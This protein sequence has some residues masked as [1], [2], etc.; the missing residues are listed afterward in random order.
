MQEQSLSIDSTRGLYKQIKIIITNFWHASLTWWWNH[1]Y[2]GML[3]NKEI[4]NSGSNC[5]KNSRRWKL[6]KYFFGNESI[7]ER[8][9]NKFD[10]T[11]NKGMQR[12]D[13][14]KK[15]SISKISSKVK[16]E[17]KRKKTV[18]GRLSTYI[19]GDLKKETKEME[20]NK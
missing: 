4:R 5:G 9:T 14:R 20:V 2:K 11:T 16:R 19:I 8:D 1:L 10:T 12:I 3:H 15:M 6:K 17:R 18:N 13:M 7:I